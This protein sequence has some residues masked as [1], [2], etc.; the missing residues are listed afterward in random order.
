M[1]PKDFFEFAKK[2]NAKMVDLKFTDLLGSWQHCS[3]PIETWDENT[4]KEGVDLTVPRSAVGRV[5]TFLI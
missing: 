5:S 1:T 2:H 4:F 3:Y